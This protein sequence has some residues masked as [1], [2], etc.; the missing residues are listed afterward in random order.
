MAF[1]SEGDR[2][3]WTQIEQFIEG[4]YTRVGLYDIASDNLTWY[5]IE[6]W[7]GGKVPQDKTIVVEELRVVNKVLFITM[8]LLSVIGVITAVGLLIFNW[9]YKRRK[10]IRMSQP[11]INTTMLVGCI[12]C[13]LTIILHGL[14][15]RFVN[16]K[17]FVTIC[18]LRSWLLTI[19]FTLAYGSMFSKVWTIYRVTTR[20]KK[21]I[22]Q[23][24]ECEFYA[25]LG[26]FVAID[27][28]IL[29]IWQVVD[30]LARKLELFP[31]ETPANTHLDIQILPQ[32][33]H[34]NCNMLNTWLGIIFG[35][36]G[37]LL[38]FGLLLA[39]ET[40]SVKAKYVNDSRFVAMSIYNVVVSLN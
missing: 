27:V 18:H 40:R 20:R 35:Y 29:T 1:N 21:N 22:R 13:L 19:G 17:V 28:A 4:N 15:G 26:I 14:D 6:K 39:Y 5:G 3:A 2:I 25:V 37:I 34:C 32:L 23:V 9:A 24:R 11:Q 7:L 12:I 10:T 8:C 31:H 36:K 30:P 16:A 33:E 38:L